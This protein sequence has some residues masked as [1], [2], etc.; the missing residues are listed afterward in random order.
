MTAPIQKKV[1]EQSTASSA[2]FAE[3]VEEAT[4]SAT[5]SAWEKVLQ[6]VKV[7]FERYLTVIS[8][9]FRLSVKAI[10][11]ALMCMITLVC[12]VM[13]MWVTILVGLTYGLTMLGLNGLWSLLIVLVLNLIVL[14]VVKRI[15]TSAL[16]S[17]E[18][19]ASTELLFRADQ[20]HT[21]G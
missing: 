6:A 8:A 1:T 21:D 20:R 16:S 19:K 3:E 13:V 7:S 5:L 2:D 11:V 10:C 9:D 18:M 17:I 12:I 14:M 15:F 4:V